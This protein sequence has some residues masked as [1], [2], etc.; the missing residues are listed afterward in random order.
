MTYST[1]IQN[2]STPYQAVKPSSSA[3]IST[4]GQT[5]SSTAGL[6]KGQQLNGEV[7]DVRNNE[8]TVKLMD[9]RILNAKTEDTSAL[10]IGNKV[11]FRVE[12]VSNSSLTLKIISDNAGSSLE[13]ILNKALDLAGLSKSSR[14]KS[15]VSELLK[16]QMSIDKNTINLLIKQSLTFK[17]TPVS[18]LVLL[19]KYQLPVTSEN[20]K[21]FEEY[22]KN[23][24]HISDDLTDMAGSITELFQ[25]ADITDEVYIKESKQLLQLL[26]NASNGD[27]E[28]SYPLTNQLTLSRESLT[29]LNN[30]LSSPQGSSIKDFINSNAIS[31]NGTITGEQAKDLLSL[32]KAS[33]VT[34][35]QLPMELEKLLN[36][37]L[38]SP[39]HTLAN[40]QTLSAVE[41]NT[42][43]L[44]GNQ[45]DINKN[46]LSQTITENQHSPDMDE[47]S[48]ELSKPT[49]NILDSLK[50]HGS[51]GESLDHINNK[52]ELLTYVAGHLDSLEAHAARTLLN[53]K[54]F[55]EL[56][57]DE[58]LSRWSLSPKDFADKEK[59]DNH[60]E[61]LAKDIRNINTFLEETALT[62]S[63]KVQGQT[64][65]LIDNLNFMNQLNHFFTYAQIPIK[66]DTGYSKS[67]LYV[68]SKRKPNAEN[69]GSVSVLLHLD[70]NNL[71]PLDVYLKLN[72]NQLESTFYCDSNDIMT[73]ISSH[74][75][76]LA[77]ILTEKGFQITAS[78]QARTK[79]VNVMK[80]ILKEDPSDT[81]GARYNFDVRA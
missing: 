28:S 18:T 71:G 8:V 79:T 22:E 41:G 29:E 25:Q 33:G 43:V 20:L 6:Y 14:N 57:K 80:E 73:L 72:K 77:D 11:T 49:K 38:S 47:I 5:G 59:L 35:T 70:M 13:E 17:D 51:F 40:T 54:D 26:L 50:T 32:L 76:T 75:N 44:T 61:T 37:T 81:F 39:S 31:E 65:Q 9:G 30:I 53:S 55:K 66:L 64:S 4:S 1:N 45:E 69:N 19:N 3:G 42:V 2:S 78:V 56:L 12:D 10:S 27:L 62:N 36:A 7:M 63:A 48:N 58:L 16:Q 68:Y 60:F 67:E 21:L 15:I 24:H 23:A 34:L 74:L 52:S 46:L